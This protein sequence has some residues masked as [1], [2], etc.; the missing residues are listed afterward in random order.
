MSWGTFSEWSPPP[1]VTTPFLYDAM[2]P[3]SN[4]HRGK[5]LTCLQGAQRSQGLMPQNHRIL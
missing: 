5:I 2:D 1:H 4:F 3:L